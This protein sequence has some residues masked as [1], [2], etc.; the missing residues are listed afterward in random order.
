MNNYLTD[1][2]HRTK[3]SSSYSSFLDLLI[4]VPQRSILGPLLFNIYTSDLFMFLHEDNEA[5]YAD[6]TTTHAMKENTLQVSKE[7]E[8]KAA[9]VFSWFPANYFKAKPKKPH[10]LLTSNEQVHL[11]LNDL[12]ITKQ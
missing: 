3:V 2:K 7:A 12:I 11:Y 8:D 9:Y 4:G 5:S 6:D 1:K 10:F